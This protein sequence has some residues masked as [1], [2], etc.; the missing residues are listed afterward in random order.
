MG[1]RAV[2]CFVAGAALAAAGGVS[3][4][5]RLAERPPMGWSSLSPGR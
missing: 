1:S 4:E 3:G 5:S 2:A